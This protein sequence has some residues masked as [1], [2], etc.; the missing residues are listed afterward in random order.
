LKP[1]V[2]KTSGRKSLWPNR[3]CGRHEASLEL[4]LIL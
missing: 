2:A 4:Q 3:I 1:F